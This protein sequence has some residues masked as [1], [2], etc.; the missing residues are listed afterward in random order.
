MAVD[1]D[2]NPPI[3]AMIPKNL[4]GH[5]GRPP[6]GEN[7]WITVSKLPARPGTWVERRGLG[8]Q[9][10]WETPLQ[11]TRYPQVID[12]FSPAGCRHSEP[13]PRAFSTGVRGRRAVEFG[14]V[15]TDSEDVGSR[16]RSAHRAERCGV[17][18]QRPASYSS[19]K[20]AVNALEKILENKSW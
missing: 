8:W 14:P 9:A 1:G 6:P 4:A 20:R 5:N 11:P 13:Y 19:E 10:A 2:R 3:K 17:V 7:P 12:R 15:G 16:S 18:V